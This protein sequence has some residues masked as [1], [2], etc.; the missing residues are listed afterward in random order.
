V[1]EHPPRGTPPQ[2]PPWIM[3]QID[4][5]GLKVLRGGNAFLAFEFRD[6]VTLEDA[7]GL[8]REMDRMIE[9]ISCT[10]FTT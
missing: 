8:A 4:E 7:S 6:G 9:G 5:P 10:K 3:V 1:T 2:A